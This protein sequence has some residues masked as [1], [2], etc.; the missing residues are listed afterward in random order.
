VQ[1]WNWWTLVPF[2]FW[3]DFK[4]SFGQVILYFYFLFYYYFFARFSNVVNTRKF[5]ILLA[6]FILIKC[7]MLEHVFFQGPMQTDSS[8]V[9]VFFKREKIHVPSK[10]KQRIITIYYSRL[11][12]LQLFKWIKKKI[13]LCICNNIDKYVNIIQKNKWYFSREKICIVKSIRWFPLEA[14]CLR[15]NKCF[16]LYS[17]LTIIMILN[18]ISDLFIFQIN[19]L[20]ICPNQNEVI[21]CKSVNYENYGI[22]K[23]RFD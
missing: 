11:I 23:S 3:H 7:E 1:Y 12:F 15:R 5:K 10:K 16:P 8:N 17:S 2:S 20:H 9:V 21:I 14:I 18:T 13:T 6:I 19:E 4:L 22:L